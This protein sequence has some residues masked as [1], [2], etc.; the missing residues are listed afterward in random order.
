MKPR[1]MMH[2]IPIKSNEI[3][4][5]ERNRPMQFSGGEKVEMNVLCALH[6]HQPGCPPLHSVRCSAKAAAWATNS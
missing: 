1:M 5:D 4:V 6:H 2:R 3:F